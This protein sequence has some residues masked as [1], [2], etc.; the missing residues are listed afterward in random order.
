MKNYI[1]LTFILFLVFSC[2]PQE[3]TK[4]PSCGSNEVF[5]EVKRTC[6]INTT[7]R[8]PVATTTSYSIVENMPETTYG[9]NYTDYDGDSPYACTVT[10]SNS[11]LRGILNYQGVIYRADESL[12]DGILYTVTLLNDVTVTPGFE[13]ATLSG[14]DV[15]VHLRSG[16]SIA[17]SIANAINNTVALYGKITAESVSDYTYQ[18]TATSLNLHGAYCECINGS[19]SSTFTTV[20]D[21]YGTTYFDYYIT[22]TD[23]NSEVKRAYVYIS[24]VD[25]A[26]VA[27]ANSSVVMTEDSASVI[28]LSYTDVDSDKATSC[29]IS[30]L[31]SNLSITSSCSCNSSGV[32]T[33]AIKGA[34][35]YNTQPAPPSAPTPLDTISMFDFSVTAN[36][37][38]S[39]TANVSGTVTPVNDAPV[40]YNMSV[41]VTEDA[42]NQAT[43][44]HS[45]ILTE[46]TDVDSD[47][48]FNYSITSALPSEVAI[49]GCLDGS[50]GLTCTLTI[51]GDY[52]PGSF[53]ISYRA[54]DGSSFSSIKTITVTIIPANDLPYFSPATAL[55]FNINESDTWIPLAGTFS[56]STAIDEENST[57]SY[58]LTDAS[59]TIQS[60]GTSTNG[61]LSDCMNLSGTSSGGDTSCTFT[62]TDGNYTGTETFYYVAYDGALYSAVRQFDV[63]VLNQSDI[64]TICQYSKYNSSTSRTECGIG[65]CIGDGS[66]LFLP[67]SHSDDSPVVYYDKANGACYV[68]QTVASWSKVAKFLPD[69]IFGEKEHVIISDIIVNEGGTSAEDSEDVF[70]DV[71][72]VSITNSVLTKPENIYFEYDEAGDGSFSRSFASNTGSD[73]AIQLASASDISANLFRIR[74]VPTSGQT[75]SSRIT[76]AIYD[77]A[78]KI[79]TV[80]FEVTVLPLSV[81]HNGWSSIQSIGNKTDKFGQPVEKNSSCTYSRD[82]C[83]NGGE[84]LSTSTAAPTVSADFKGAIFKTSNGCYI[85]TTPGKDG[86]SP[87]NSSCNYSL[88]LCDSGQSCYSTLSTP[89]TA[90]ADSVGAIFKTATSCYQAAAIGTDDWI[91]IV[92]STTNSSLSAK[93]SFCNITE[94]K[95]YDANSISKCSYSL[96]ACNSGEACVS[97]SVGSPVGTVSADSIGA[98]FRDAH[99]NCYKSTATGTAS[100]TQVYTSSD[101][102]L[103]DSSNTCDSV[104]SSA[105]CASD[106]SSGN[107]PSSL[108]LVAADNSYVYFY[109][110]SNSALDSERCWY[111][112]GSSWKSYSSSSQITIAWEAFTISGTATVSGYNVYRRAYNESFDYQNPLNKTMILPSVLTYMDNGTNS[113]KAPTPGIVY[114]Y[115]VRPIVTDSTYTLE[116]TSNSNLA[117]VRVVSAPDNKVFVHRWM[118]NKKICSQMNSDSSIEMNYICS[119][120]GF[121]DTDKTGYSEYA[122][123]PDQYIY[124]LGSDYLVNRFEV[125]CPYTK[126]GCNTDDGSCIDGRVPVNGTDGS[127]GDYFYDRSTGVCWYNNAGAWG[128]MNGQTRDLDSGLGEVAYLPPLTNVNQTTASNI[129]GALPATTIE[130]IGSLGASSLPTRKLQI[131]YSHWDITGDFEDTDATSYELGEGLNSLSKCNSSNADGISFGYTDD[132]LPDSNTFYSIPGIASSSIRSVYTGSSQTKNCKSMFGVQDFAGNVKEWTSNSFTRAANNI[133]TS[134]FASADATA[135]NSA[136]T[137]SFSEDLTSPT[138]PCDD[139]DDDGVC[140]SPISDF[141]LEDR[142]FEAYKFDVAV[143]LPITGKYIDTNDSAYNY[144]LEINSSITANALHEDRITLNMDTITTNGQAAY[145][146]VGGGYDSGHDSGVYS[147]E[148]ITPTTISPEIGFRCAVPVP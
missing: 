36:G 111:S 61:V 96:A 145:M 42:T 45:F 90:S 103:D 91:E 20:T 130:G 107:D 92:S 17:S 47:A 128:V 18:S 32:C 144:M 9:I 46:A 93:S 39:S 89:P 120:V 109:N 121:G 37:K 8:L 132:Q 23:G 72:S 108:G 41:S 100:W 135:F 102:D 118:A 22:D 11:G 66:P 76:F 56:L 127:S 59:G 68:S 54:D 141:K 33:V 148:L 83:N 13:Y 29:S 117:K 26:P 94:V 110:T 31:N 146:V 2:T 138:G 62:P 71:S 142:D 137:Y 19:C 126:E 7:P 81:I 115:E 25:A 16:I 15:T 52:N 97:E 129:C 122:T 30:N 48:P 1:F 40:A 113:R 147:F 28:T 3:V 87:I 106:L 104:L 35:N 139:S 5:D 114:Y 69:V 75:G 4:N 116:V 34:T 14:Y 99:G 24:N 79:T 44:T 58:Y 101:S 84:C 60:S 77:T 55:S 112:D 10:N 136:G 123:Y 73:F 51:N 133:F 57:L 124:D 65:G 131:A 80:S 134:S 64:P 50:S 74:I 27:T 105:S 53:T 85:A 38:T 82:K 140:E 70:V 143:G 67:S 21:F 6:V 49:S 98:I 78:S 125:G 86:W 43:Y 63:N 12:I 119:Y 95:R 88:N